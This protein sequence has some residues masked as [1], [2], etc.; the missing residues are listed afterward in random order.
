MIVSHPVPL[1]SPTEC[2]GGGRL[3][4]SAYL[5]GT[6]QTRAHICDV[7]GSPSRGTHIAPLARIIT[8]CALPAAAGQSAAPVSHETCGAAPLWSSAPLLSYWRRT[9]LFHVK[10]ECG[11]EVAPSS[12]AGLA[13]LPT[14]ESP[15]THKNVRAG[16]RAAVNGARRWHD[17][18]MAMSIDVPSHALTHYD[19]PPPARG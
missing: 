5:P 9:R 11:A 4:Y 1:G 19:V 3:L 18:E 8:E 15:A 2:S 7:T 16:C 6:S 17:R 12:L 14:G 13:G 10:H